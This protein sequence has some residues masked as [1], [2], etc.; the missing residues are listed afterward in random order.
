MGGLLPPPLGGGLS[1]P[2]GSLL[3]GRVFLGWLR[4]LRL[5]P[6]LVGRGGW[7]AL[8]PIPV[9]PPYSYCLDSEPF[10]ITP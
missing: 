7:T 2:E 9:G 3:W 1:A 6:P 8:A 5:N 4:R 10:P